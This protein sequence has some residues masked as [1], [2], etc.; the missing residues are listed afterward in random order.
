MTA[1]SFD[2]KYAFDSELAQARK[3]NSANITPAFEQRIKEELA[4]AQQK[5]GEKSPQYVQL[6]RSIVAFANVYDAKKHDL[7]RAFET[8]H[9][10]SVE[11]V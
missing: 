10:K 6:Q 11:A 4:Q 2:Q 1:S 5:Y 8:L 7:G 9:V 3:A